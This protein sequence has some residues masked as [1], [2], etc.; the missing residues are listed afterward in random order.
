MNRLGCERRIVDADECV[1]LEP[2]LASARDEL[3]G[4]IFSPGDESGDA[5][6]FTRAASPSTAPASAS[7]FRW[8]ET[9]ATLAARRTDGIAGVETDGGDDRR[10]MPT[11]WRSAASRRCC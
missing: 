8:S 7:T 5:H 6:T 2:A 3:V 9:V 10:P 11:S 4:G 1:A